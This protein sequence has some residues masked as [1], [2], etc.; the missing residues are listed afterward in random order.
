MNDELS[1]IGKRLIELRAKL[2]VREGQKEYQE[3]CKHIREEIA[4]L[5]AITAKPAEKPRKRWPL[6]SEENDDRRK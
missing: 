6:A 1:G 4:R 5:E 2:A 3:N